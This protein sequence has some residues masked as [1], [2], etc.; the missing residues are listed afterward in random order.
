VTQERS[1]AARPRWRLFGSLGAAV[2]V[3]DQIVK[4]W[5]A[6]NY[7]VG[8]PAPIAGDL[9]RINMTHNQGAIFG[10]FQGSA[11][12]FGLVS[13]AVVGVIVWYEARAGAS[14]LVTLALGLLVGGAVGNLVDRI[15]LGYVIDFMDA[16]IGAWRFFTFNVA[17]SA[18]SGAIL[19]LLLLA[20]LPPR[21]EAA[22]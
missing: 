22:G 10:L 3:V 2:I 17:D 4:A 11:V 12:V 6:G 7:V 14:L 19:L 1:R 20:V 5:I 13:L 21:T 18:I 9:L 16:G 8:T 15:R